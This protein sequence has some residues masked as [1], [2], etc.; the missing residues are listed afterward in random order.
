MV[1]NDCGAMPQKLRWTMIRNKLRIILE[2]LFPEEKISVDDVPKGKP[3]DYATNLALKIA[4][5]TGQDMQ[6]VAEM[7]IKRIDSPII[8][9]AFFCPPGF[10]NFEIKPEAI[11]DLLSTDLTIDIGKGARILIEFVSV[12]P[13]GPINVVNARAAAVGDTLVR[14]MNRTG[15]RAASE[16]YVNDSGR[17]IDLLAE[18][19]IQRMNEFRNEKAEI[20]PEGY[21]HE[22][23]KDVARELIGKGL[24]DFAAIRD[25]SIDYFISSQRRS[26]EGFGVAFDNWVYE[27]EIHRKGLIER[28]LQLFENKDLT[29]RQDNAL[30]FK[31]TAFG[32]DK[33]RVVIKSDGQYHYRLS[34]IAYHLDK[35]ERKYDRLID[36]WGPDH[37]GY[38]KGLI[39]G[40]RALGYPADL[41]RVLIVQHVRLKKDGQVVS[42]SKRAGTFTTLDELLGMVPRDVARF[43]FLMRSCSQHLDFDLDL[44]LKQSEENPVYYVQYAHARIQSILRFAQEKDIAPAAEVDIS[45]IKEKEELALA[46]GILKFCEVLE[47]AAQY[48]EPSLITHYLIELARSFHHFYHQHKVVG[49]DE[50][51]TRARLF[52]VKK[53]AQTIKNGLELLGVSCPDQM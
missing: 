45:L 7:L 11:L 27:S 25:Y 26:L 43:F 44:A 52:L 21:H 10:I 20:P 46:R 53:T 31:A 51:L 4:A 28:V 8:E 35:I 6:S 41:C 49:D 3:G 2:D 9:K 39:G 42:M 16:F 38:I 32:D 19:V 5:R 24:K 40:I 29:Y 47:D 34:D 48:L 36:I 23:I 33:D 13:T 15:F 1:W 17:Q 22:Y 30:F 18:S 37:H 50:R 14:I 12:N